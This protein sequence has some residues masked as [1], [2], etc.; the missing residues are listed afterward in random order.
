MAILLKSGG[1]SL[2]SCFRAQGFLS[3]QEANYYSLKLCVCVG[4]VGCEC[5]CLWRTDI[6]FPH[7]GVQKIERHPVWML[8]TKYGL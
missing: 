2:S 3:L 6:K 8:A 4:W 7:S 1:M 5:R